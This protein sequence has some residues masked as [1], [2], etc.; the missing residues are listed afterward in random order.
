MDGL[1]VIHLNSRSLYGNISK[2][3]D[4]LETRQQRFDTRAISETRLSDDNELQDGFDG[5]VL[6]E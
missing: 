6:A 4:Y 2:I 3:K 5:Y 1:S